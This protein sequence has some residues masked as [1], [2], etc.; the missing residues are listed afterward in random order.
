MPEAKPRGVFINPT[1]AQ[2]SIFESGRMMY[3]GLKGSDRYTL[4]YLELDPSQPSLGVYDFYLFNYHHAT[5]AWLDTK[6]LRSLPGL[7]LTFVLEVSPGDPFVLCPREDFDAYLPLD[8]SLVHP[9]PRVFPFPR[10]LELPD[11][12]EP[13]HERDIPTIGTFGF[14]T[15]GKG[16]EL[17]VDAVGREFDRARVRIN[18]PP[19]TYADQGT[20]N[21]QRRPYAA[22]LEELCRA[23][24]RPGIEV[25]FTR[26]YLDERGL[27]DWCRQNT[28]NCFL[29]NR[30][31]PGLSATT[32]QAI[33]AARPLAV[34]TNPT[35]RHIH[36]YLTPY[37]FRSLRESIAESLPGVM[38][39]RT[40]W[41]S[42]QFSR[43][44]EEVLSALGLLPARTE[45]PV[46]LEPTPTP[47]RKRLLL[48][49]HVRQQ[50][51]IH[52]Y[53]RDMAEALRTSTRYE[54]LYEECDDEATFRKAVARTRPDLILYNHYPATMPWVTP[55]L[56]ASLA[57]PQAGVMHEVTQEAA[58][59]AD[60]AL[61]DAHLCPD[62]TLIPRN[63][64][65]LKIPRLVPSYMNLETPPEVPTIGSFGFPF[66]DKGFG[67][68]V[69]MVQEE[70]DRARILLHLPQNDIVPTNVEEVLEAVRSK[71]R[72]PGIEAAVNHRFLSKQELLLF[73]S[74][75]SLNV[76]LYDEHKREGIS[77]V[78][79]K[80]MAVGRPVAVNRSGM[81]RHIHGA[82]PSITLGDRSLKEIMASGI[83][84]LVP[85]LNEWSEGAFVKGVEEALD[86]VVPQPRVAPGTE[87]EPL[88]VAME[89]LQTMAQ[90]NAARARLQARGLSFTGPEHAVPGIGPIGDPLKSW[91]VLKTIECIEE[92]HPPEAAVL[93]LGA[94]SCE[95]LPILHRMGFTNLSGIDL[96]PRIR[97]MPHADRIRYVEGNFHQTGF[98]DAS[99]DVITAI[100]VIEHGFEPEALLRE[101]SRLLKPGGRFI[102]SVDYWPQKISTEGMMIFDLTW[103]IFSEAELKAFFQD[104][105][106]HGLQARGEQH[107]QAESPAI[108]YA[109]RDYAFGWFCLEK[110]AIPEPAE[111]PTPQGAVLWIA[112]EEAASA[113]SALGALARLPAL[114]PRRPLVA[115]CP[116]SLRS[117]HAANPWVVHVEGYDPERAAREPAY[118][119][120]LAERVRSLRPTLAL[121]PGLPDG[122]VVAAVRDRCGATDSLG[123]GPGWKRVLDLES[124]LT[125]ERDRL[126]ALLK[127]LGDEAEVMSFATPPPEAEM[128]AR[129]LFRSEGLE[130]G[131]TV[132]LHG[133]GP[134]RVPE[135]F[136][137]LMGELV[138]QEGLEGVHLRMA[139]AAGEPASG[140]R[141]VTCSGPAAAL[142][143]LRRVRLAAGGEGLTSVLAALAGVPQLVVVGGD[144]FG[145]FHPSG[146]ET[147]MAALPLD[148][149]GCLGACPYP[150][151]SCT[152]AVPQAVLRKAW[153]EALARAPRKPR[154][155]V[156]AEP[157][158]IP[159][160]AGALDLAGLLNP[161]AVQLVRAGDPGSTTLRF[162]FGTLDASGLAS[163][164]PLHQ[165]IRALFPE[166]RVT[167]VLPEALKSQLG[168]AF[169]GDCLLL[170]GSP[171]AQRAALEAQAR[172]P[173]TKFFRSG[174]GPPPGTRQPQ[175]HI[176]DAAYNAVGHHPGL[177][178][179]MAQ[180]YAE[181]G[182]RSVFYLPKDVDPASMAPHAAVPLFSA[183]PYMQ[184]FE[185]VDSAGQKS[186]LAFNR[187]VE[188]D[189]RAFPV[190]AVAPGD[191]LF[192]NL[193]PNAIQ[194]FFPL[195]QRL[196][197]R[198]PSLRIAT[199]FNLPSGLLEGPEGSV[200]VLSEHAR[201]HRA[202]FEGLPPLLR[203]RVLWGISSEPEARAFSRLCGIPVHALPLAVCGLPEPA[204]VGP[205]AREGFHLGT[206]GGARSDK[207]IPLWPALAR[208]LL[209]RHPELHLTFH[210]SGSYEA[211]GY[212]PVLT[213]LQ[214]MARTE[215][216]LHVLE[217][218]LD[219]ATYY[220][221]LQGFDGLLM[222]HDPA[223]WRSLLSGT[224]SEAMH[225]GLPAVV[226]GGTPMADWIAAHGQHGAAYPEPTAEAIAEAASACLADRT[227]LRAQ[228]EAVGAAYRAEHGTALQV[229]RLL[230]W[231]GRTQP[232][233]PAA[234]FDRPP[235]ELPT[236][237][238]DIRR[239]LPDSLAGATVL[240]LGGKDAFLAQEALARGAQRVEAVLFPGPSGDPLAR[241]HPVAGQGL[242]PEAG[243]TLSTRDPRTLRPL[244]APAF[245]HVFLL[246]IL[247]EAFDPE[248]LLAF[249]ASACAG[250]L[251]L[252]GPVAD[253]AV[254]SGR[255]P[256]RLA[257]RSWARPTEAPEPEAG[258][259]PERAWLQATLEGL[260]FGVQTWELRHGLPTP[261]G[262]ARMILRARRV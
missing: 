154:L 69:E 187:L 11:Q 224:F 111:A 230:T 50:C 73:L 82:Q 107:F 41:A 174:E 119:E 185:G 215:A 40:D 245:S 101:V 81:F 190:E 186:A 223:F 67:R 115:V 38:R 74:Q 156:P 120:A 248:G 150:T 221:T 165:Q 18:V 220:R 145:R 137:R 28:L 57:M 113:A 200:E 77:S 179:S 229:E 13:H 46:H 131:R 83:A 206:L 106:A 153:E 109:D 20:L 232:P 76:F 97:L 54:C 255:P 209:P 14:A 182:F 99:F 59:A 130:P 204:S 63:P 53:G 56:T 198:D 253:G 225:F 121:G 72:K 43:R 260:G 142:A 191:T 65:A 214:A 88:G 176:L 36:P 194:G 196:L 157:Q 5:L 193:L 12:L 70:F 98:P 68:L 91:D 45:A 207:G 135:G 60:A 125:P 9:D 128:E 134:G 127:A 89:V 33:A 32:D 166:A 164:Q 205:E 122:P 262:S 112:P 188:R 208:I 110:T 146:P 233:W 247:H 79:E 184:L 256:L 105:R 34:G 84:P 27:I 136:P 51:G 246:D 123:F 147:V 141:V 49:N 160:G 170:T 39:M 178:Q 239:L 26:E 177:A 15:P 132:V 171:E 8:P 148:C 241:W 7:K 155:V 240:D 117:L 29:Y 169:Q 116:E 228:R 6:S 212:G 235:G 180:A 16:F 102:A 249:A 161:E 152:Q 162:G 75:N 64:L 163:L 126:Q 21:L 213:E 118:V 203:E 158:G 261:E 144:H 17:V 234:R 175:V 92:H 218:L 31:Q 44:F 114:L 231:T 226:P 167:W 95:I 85:Y 78:V 139:D 103:R 181:R 172:G 252:E 217:G 2:C 48:V 37:P 183:S 251:I 1:R 254:G 168:E 94:F 211:L 151:R 237:P 66:R 80:A 104:G 222:T 61:F 47:S 227:R 4:D 55:A 87:A 242:L 35:F 259:M 19:G 149:Y 140:L 71:I 143:F 129:E 243:L 62:P 22:Y 244:E 195:F 23:V 257:A 159:G 238:G 58:D 3:E 108:H 25:E 10:P 201:I 138:H 216:R 93:D 100:S 90:V 96:N 210:F 42:G 219:E 173:W 189:L 192:V 199:Y 24:A 124:P 30:V 133:M 236:L 86:R 197:E 52:Q 250:E 202:A 258:W